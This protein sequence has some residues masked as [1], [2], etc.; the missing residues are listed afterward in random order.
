MKHSIFLRTRIDALYKNIT[1]WMM[2]FCCIT[3]F[4]AYSK[5][6]YMVTAGGGHT[7]WQAITHG[8]QVAA[9]QYNYRIISRGTFESINAE[10]QLSII[11]YSKNYNCD[12]LIL[13]PYNQLVVDQ[14]QQ[15]YFKP[16]ILIDRK[17]KFST[18]H[19]VKTDDYQAG[20]LAAKQLLVS[21]TKKFKLGYILTNT[22]IAHLNERAKGFSDYLMKKQTFEK[23]ETINLGGSVG[24]ARQQIYL[25]KP[26]LNQ[27]DIIYSTNE[28]SSLAINQDLDLPTTIKIG[29]D[30]HPLL[31]EA[32]LNSKMLG[33]VSQ[34]AFQI[35]YAS[36]SKLIAHI[37]SGKPLNSLYLNAN[38]IDYAFLQKLPVVNC[39]NIYRYLA[40][41][42]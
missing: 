16:I 29:F 27:A 37:E 22:Q 4:H 31:I 39:Q 32:T 23:L 6:L 18:M 41:Q 34:N 21:N 1:L 40:Q 36:A 15:N 11:E 26:I 3:S 8:A 30:C 2:L 5:C 12:G 7:F 33:F 35:G 13:A 17:P 10:A 14:L 20:Q 42:N 9:K 38:F 24:S 19:V 25:K 28:L